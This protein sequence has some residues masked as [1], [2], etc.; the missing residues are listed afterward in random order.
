MSNVYLNGKIIPEDEAFIPA[1]DRSILF[2]DAAY[3]TLRTYSGKFFRLPEHLK[4][5]RK[6]LTGMELT[7]PV[8]D[9]DIIAGAGMLMDSGHAPDSRVRLT[10]TGGVHSEEI[11][12]R[13]P[14]PP[15]LIMTARPL[16]APPTAA[17]ERGVRVVVASARIHTHS[18]LPRL[19]TTNRLMH[20][21]A[22]E[23]AL[24]K[25]AWDALF[26]DEN[27]CVLEGTM[28]NVFFVFGEELVT[29]PLSS[30]LL[31]GVTRDM[32]LETARD[33]NIAIR[34]APVPLAEVGQATEAILTSTTIE[35]LPIRE[36]ENQRIGSG[37]PGPIWRRLIERYR[38]KVS[39]ETGVLQTPVP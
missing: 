9:E 37:R 19:K 28:T 24:A 25:A 8:S 10:V 11:R 35:L 7:L 32:V 15:S 27:D 22:K 16:T 2:G 6:T 12:L 23:D 39:E 33:E 3:E 34:E 4:R 21:M 14:N 26:C 38:A 17:Y 1:N 5:L 18:P 31:A 29:P 20:L 36:I 13:R 30:P